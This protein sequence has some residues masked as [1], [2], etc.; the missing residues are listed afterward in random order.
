[1]QGCHAGVA[2]PV[3]TPSRNDDRL[4]SRYRLLLIL[5][6]E[7]GLPFQDGQHLFDRM[8]MRRRSATGVAPLLEDA[9]LCRASDSRY[10]HA[11]IH[12]GT[13]LITGLVLMIDDTH[14]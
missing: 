3:V 9:E 8:Q 12:P 6:P 4:T 13:P 2:E 11:G 1:M 7:F 5:D 10:P 14:H